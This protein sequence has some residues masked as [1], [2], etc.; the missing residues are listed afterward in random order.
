MK[1]Q[2]TLFQYIKEKLPNH[3][4]LVDE[5]SELLHIS[6]DSA[7]RRIRGEKELSF[8]ELEKLSLQ[9]EISIDSIFQIKTNNIIFKDFCICPDKYSIKDWLKQILGDLQR[10]HS[11]PDKEIIYSAKDPPLFHYFQFPEIAAFKIFFWEKTLFHFPQ[12]IDKKFAIDDFDQEIKDMG[13]QILGLATKIPT[14]E[15][16][17]EDT[18][19]I[20]F[21]QIEYYWVSGFFAYKEDIFRLCDKLIIWL[22]HIQKQA[23]CGFKFRFGSNDEGIPD[24]YHFYENEVV[25]ND[26]TILVKMG[27]ITVVYI[28]Y[29][30]CSLLSTLYPEYCLQISDFLNGLMKNSTLIS[31]VNA[32]ERSRFFNKLRTKIEVFRENI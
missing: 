25:L 7:Y 16:W 8:S 12:F 2:V 10:I 31:S 11:V 9:F 26:N 22:N 13:D 30:V 6:Y 23:E 28:T 3:I 17:N 29:N 21:K 24:S 32:K 27:D 1:N 4:S 18:F 19:N 20:M 15:I 5:I 14:T